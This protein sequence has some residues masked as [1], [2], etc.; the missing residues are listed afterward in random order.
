MLLE[1]PAVLPREAAVELLRH[2]EL[3][4]LTGDDVLE[5]VREGAP[6]AEEQRLERRGGDPEQLRDLLV[7]AALELAHHE[8]L[9]LRGRD[10][11]Q[12]L[13]EAVEL[14]LLVRH[15]GRDVADELDLRRAGG[16]LAPPLADEVVG[17]RE[18]P[19]RRVPRVLPALERPQGVHEGRLRDVLGVGVVAEDRVGVAVDVA[20]VSAVQVV[21]RGLGA[22]ALFGHRHLVLPTIVDSRCA[23]TP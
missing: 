21:Q 10:L 18:E 14:D 5:L 7:R 20:D 15:P 9:A 17:D 8:R 23:R 16:R 1:A 13:D 19:A 22:R 6:G 11:L 12:S 4:A 3:G 2:R